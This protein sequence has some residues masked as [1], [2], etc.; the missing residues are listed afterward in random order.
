MADKV[1]SSILK[2]FGYS[3][4]PKLLRRVPIQSKELKNIKINK[5]NLNLNNKNIKILSINNLNELNDF[6]ENLNEIIIKN[7]G[8]LINSDLNNNKIDGIVFDLRGIN[9]ILQLTEI[10]KQL[11]PLISKINQS[12]KIVLIGGDT[13]NHS[14]NV[15]AIATSEAVGGFAKA[16]AFE[17][18]GKGITVNALQIPTSVNLNASSY[19]SG[20]LQFFLSNRSAFISGQV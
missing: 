15:G 18:G 2:L 7:G 5:N 11:N 12:G 9:K 6:N 20:V 4:G 19:E 14:K 3:N 8:N 1:L 16:L 10:Y 17:L 13:I